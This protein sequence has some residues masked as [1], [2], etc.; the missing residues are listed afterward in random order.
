[1]VAEE[2]KKAPRISVR[3][4]GRLLRL[5]DEKAIDDSLSKR[6]PR[7]FGRLSDRFREALHTGYFR[8][9]TF[10]VL[11]GLLVLTIIAILIRK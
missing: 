8:N 5:F 11:I 2:K 7:L 1:M 4:I 10:I 3:T 9:Y 6:L